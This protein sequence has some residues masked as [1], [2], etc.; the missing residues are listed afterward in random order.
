MDITHLPTNLETAPWAGP[1][2]PP[3]VAQSSPSSV[4]SSPHKQKLQLPVTKYKKKLKRGR[5][6]SAS[7]SLE[8]TLMPFSFLC[9]V[10]KQSSSFE[11]CGELACTYQS[12]IPQPQALAGPMRGKVTGQEGCSAND[13]G[14]NVKIVC[15]PDCSQGVLS[16]STSPRAP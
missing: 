3:L 6:L 2:T 12:H 16:D 1:F 15:D 7:F 14:W 10:V 11:S 8:E 13:K 5:T 4:L 9:N